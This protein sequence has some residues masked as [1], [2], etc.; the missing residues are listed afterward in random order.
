MP[1]PHLELGKLYA[2]AGRTDKAISE[3]LS[4]IRL[5]P[6]LDNAHYKLAQL[7]QRAGQTELANKHFAEYR[8]IRASRSAQEEAERRQRLCLT[9]KQ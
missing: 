2:D 1:E 4:A 3:L 5:S 6:N 7:Y 8:K 9:E